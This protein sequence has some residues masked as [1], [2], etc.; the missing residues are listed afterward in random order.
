VSLR[1]HERK[2]FR[3]EFEPAVEPWIATGPLRNP[4]APLTT[5]AW[6][7]TLPASVTV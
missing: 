3:S 6:L 4:D 7:A 1:W 5:V 2:R